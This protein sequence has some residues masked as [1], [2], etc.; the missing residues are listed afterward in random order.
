MIRWFS[1]SCLKKIHG[2][3]HFGFTSFTIL[4]AD[5]FAAVLSWQSGHACNNPDVPSRHS[6]VPEHQHYGNAMHASERLFY[7][8]VVSTNSNPPQFKFVVHLVSY[9]TNQKTANPFEAFRTWNN[10]NRH[11]VA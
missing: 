1:L 10:L 11:S 3:R 9:G 7:C 6:K 5:N 4:T 8:L 2:S